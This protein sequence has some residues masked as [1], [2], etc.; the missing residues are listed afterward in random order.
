[1]I[2]LV[3]LS[4]STF[5]IFKGSDDPNEYNYNNFRIFKTQDIVGYTIVG[6][7]GNQPY[8]FKLRNDPINTENITVSGEPR[9]LILSK[10]T[11]YLTMEPNLTSKSVIG[12]LE[13]A[14]IISRNLG[15]YNRETIGAIT[16]PIEN[17]PTP[18]A[19]CNNITRTENVILFQLG[20]ETKVSVDN[21]CILVQGINEWEIIR[22]SDRLVYDILEL[23]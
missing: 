13:V 6:Y 19:T 21:S 5:F 23:M 18:V 2:F 9:E 12:A 4:V 11:V 7:V 14:N 3:I 8:N 10:P 16:S 17:N 1:M 22:A 15:I 20:N